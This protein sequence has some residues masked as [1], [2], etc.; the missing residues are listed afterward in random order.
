MNHKL[1]KLVLGLAA[2][3][4]FS[5]QAIAGPT[6]V[7]STINLGLLAAGNGS[8]TDATEAPKTSFTDN[9]LFTAPTS[10]FDAG[11]QTTTQILK[12]ITVDNINLLTAKLINTST[13]TTLTGSTILYSIPGVGSSI[14]IANTSLV[15]G[16][17]YDLQVTGT[18]TGTKGGNF[19]GTYNVTPV[20]PVPEPTEG[21][22]LLSG[23]GLMGFIAS[24]RRT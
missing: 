15:A 17:T 16:T 3:C 10:T 5:A 2:A 23:L 21:A 9:F 4:A 11:V 6:P 13:N 12:S 1:S 20:S 24:R 7:V 18:V 14:N 19:S 8:F 22:L